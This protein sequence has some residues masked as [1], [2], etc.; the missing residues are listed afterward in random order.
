MSQNTQ[1]LTRELVVVVVAAVDSDSPV[2]I[3][4]GLVWSILLL[5]M[6]RVELMLLNRFCYLTNLLYVIIYILSS[7]YNNWLCHIV[8]FVLLSLLANPLL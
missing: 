5:I 1:H 2:Y 4:H 3:A 7:D 6:P 8:I